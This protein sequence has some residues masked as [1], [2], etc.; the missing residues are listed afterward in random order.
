M[1]QKLAQL[2]VA[3]DIPRVIVTKCS[4]GPDDEINWDTQYSHWH[5]PENMLDLLSDLVNKWNDAGL[6]QSRVR[7]GGWSFWR[8]L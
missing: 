6:G 2:I 1:E 4:P 5:V 7:K 3:F 8:S